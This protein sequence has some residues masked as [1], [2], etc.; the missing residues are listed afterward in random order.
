MKN[1]IYGPALL[2][3]KGLATVMYTS[4]IG[5][6][7]RPG[8]SG[9]VEKSLASMAEVVEMYEMSGPFDLFVKINTASR[10]AIEVLAGNILQLEGVE[11]TFNM[12][13]IGEKYTEHAPDAPVAAFFGLGVEPG[14]ERDVEL[15]LLSGD[16]IRESY[17]MIYPYGLLIK[18]GCERERDIAAIS[19]RMLHTEGVQACDVFI[20]S[21]RIK[22]QHH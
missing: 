9:R 10:Q 22:P 11:K 4:F 18:A 5:I 15:A 3:H 16:N 6:Y 14:K 20:I 21:R 2:L 13:I 8:Q 17:A 7:V 19:D 12:L 1:V